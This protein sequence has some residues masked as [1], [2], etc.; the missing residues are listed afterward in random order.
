MSIF[1]EALRD[2]NR[3]F[4]DRV[5]NINPGHDTPG[6]LLDIDRERRRIGN[7]LDGGLGVLLPLFASEESMKRFERDVLRPAGQSLQ[8]LAGKLGQGQVGGTGFESLPESQQN[9]LNSLFS[10]G[11]GLLGQGLNFSPDLSGL[12][13]TARGDFLNS[14]PYLNQTFGQASKALTD[15]YTNTVMPGIGTQFEGRVGSP[16]HQRAQSMAQ[17]N[18]AQG[19]GFLGNQIF[20]G[21]FQNER[22]RQLQ[23]S[24][25]LPTFGLNQAQTQASFPLQSLQSVGSIAG[26][27]PY[28]DPMFQ[29]RGAGVLGGAL[30]GASIGAGFGGGPGA[31]IGGLLGG[32]LG[33]LQ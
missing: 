25:F 8:G 12:Q 27:R 4:N 30:G 19:L 32:G 28:G 3:E 17:G 18:L 29:N 11:Q 13:A 5:L 1:T 33:F 16:A 7:E 20:G 15:A 9:L 2:T 26:L 21:N 23:A 14:N 31:I 10:R 24:Q 6:F 22:N